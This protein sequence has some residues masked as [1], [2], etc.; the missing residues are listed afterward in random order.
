MPSQSLACWRY[1]KANTPARSSKCL[2]IYMKCARRGM[3]WLDFAQANT[4]IKERD[5]RARGGVGALSIF[6]VAPLIW[7][8]VSWLICNFNSFLCCLSAGFGGFFGG[9]L[10]FF[11]PSRSFSASDAS[12]YFFKGHAWS[13]S[14]RITYS[15]WLYLFMPLFDF[16]NWTRWNV[17][18]IQL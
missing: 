4:Y 10:F 14:C 6:I 2:F 5:K 16:N 13:L 3:K 7:G 17:S 8:D 12:T 9:G 1:I 15:G 11:S 18:F